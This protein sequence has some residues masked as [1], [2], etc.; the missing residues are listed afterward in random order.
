M[1]RDSLPLSFDFSFS[2]FFQ[3]PGG[4][5]TLQQSEWL[6]YFPGKPITAHSIP[7]ITTH[8]S[9]PGVLIRLLDP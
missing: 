8:P 6:L 9:A 7:N 3:R 1:F 2:F 5:F 4:K